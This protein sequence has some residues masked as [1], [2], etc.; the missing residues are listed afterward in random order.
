MAKTI[1]QTVK[2][3]SKPAKVF[4][5]YMDPK[6]HSAVTGQPASRPRWVKRPVV[7][8]ALLVAISRAKCSTW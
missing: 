3:A 1:Q 5:L 2:F 7:P 8:S 6:L 4:A